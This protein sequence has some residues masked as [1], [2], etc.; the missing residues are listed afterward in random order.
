MLT[1]KT[2]EKFLVAFS[3]AGEQR[4]IV[5][6]IAEVVEQRLGWG[7][8]FLDEWFEEALAGAAADLKLQKIYS[9]EA[10]IVVFCASKEYDE[11]K[12]TIVEWDAI[13]ARHMKL[14][15]EPDRRAADR[16]VPIR[17]ADGNVEGLLD[18]AIWVDTRQ[19]STKY[20]ANLV[21]QRVR[22][23]VQNAGKPQVFVAET[24]PDLEDE[25][26]IVS[27]P[28]LKA[29]LEEQCG[30][31]V[32]P[33]STLVDLPPTKYRTALRTCI[34][35]SIAFVQLLSRYPWKGGGFDKIQCRMAEDCG[36]NMFRFRGDIDM[37]LIKRS[38]P[39]HAAF[40]EA[41]GAIAG[42]FA[43]LASTVRAFQ[44]PEWTAPLFWSSFVGS[45]V[46]LPLW[47][48]FV[49][50][51]EPLLRRI[52]MRFSLFSFIALFLGGLLFPS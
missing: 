50:R 36:V 52:G 30:C 48:Y 31:V 29:F 12:W 28:R 49:L 14:R 16:I 7:T 37:D 17:V 51:A 9:D 13:R 47:S 43:I 11:K 39:N 40:L 26:E 42:S 24:T 38:D 19:R 32:L 45:L 20:I 21:V 1:R 33:S 6:E 23:F 22:A 8:V 27:R 44:P 34:E 10:D 5:R 41:N 35:R 25:S 2:P 46:L 18:N 3:F 4:A 15:A